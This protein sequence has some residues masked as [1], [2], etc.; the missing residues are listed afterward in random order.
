MA[1][2]LAH[3]DVRAAMCNPRLDDAQRVDIFTSL[4][5]AELAPGVRNFIAL[6]IQNDRILLLPS[7]AAQFIALKN[8]HEDTAQ[9]EITSAFAL[10]E[11]QLRPL[12]AALEK[13][14]GIKLKP[15]VTVDPSL[16]GGVRVVVG[17][18][19]LDTSV[20]AQLLRMRDTLAG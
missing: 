6:L 18:Q 12:L 20:Q 5:R 10:S 8:R 14:F 3:A 9:A 15:N 1:Q 19:V 2:L 13:K 11:E 4:M 7:I 16:I 17:D